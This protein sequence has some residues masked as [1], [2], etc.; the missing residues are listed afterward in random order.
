MSIKKYSISDL[1]SFAYTNIIPNGNF[2]NATGWDDSVSVI[3]AINNTLLVTGDGGN[4]NPGTDQNTGYPLANGKKFFVS[5]KV[6]VTNAVCTQFVLQA[7]TSGDDFI[8]NI[9][10]HSTPAIN[11]V[12]DINGVVTIGAQVGNFQPKLT[13]WYADA[14]TANGKVM[15]V[16]EFYAIDLTSL[17][18]AGNEPLVADCLNIFK[19]VDGTL[20]PNLSKTLIL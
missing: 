17:F 1:K 18:G 9:K 4:V 19:F 8:A 6:Q 11:T 12:Y 10:V 7:Y 3:S 16:Q 2:V 14:G 15:K 13:H 5:V 20:Q